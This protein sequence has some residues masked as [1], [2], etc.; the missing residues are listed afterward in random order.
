MLAVIKTGGKQYLVSPGDNRTWND[1]IAEQD[2]PENDTGLLVTEKKAETMKALNTLKATE[3]DIIERR[4][5]FQGEVETL[6]EIA[7]KYNLSRERIRQIEHQALKKLMK[8]RL[9]AM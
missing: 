4:F 3:R 9:K 6:K 7:K 8:G 5:G 1:L 2:A